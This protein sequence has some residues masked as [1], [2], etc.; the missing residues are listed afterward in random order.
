MKN[1]LEQRVEICKDVLKHLESGKIESVRNSFFDNR[2]DVIYPLIGS[3]DAPR[4]AQTALEKAKVCEVC[5]K[6]AI[7]VS[8][9]LRHNAVTL[10]ELESMREDV[11][12]M[13]PLL[14]E[15]F[16]KPLLDALETAY[17]G[18]KYSTWNDS[19]AIF[20][21]FFEENEEPEERLKILM[22]HV[23]EHN[24]YLEFWE[25]KIG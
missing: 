13:P 24:G 21:S 6:G 11:G 22:E 2:N 15:V 14:V 4:S 20:E 8:W 9:I 23:I 16:G 17:E 10:R 18:H 12:S 19:P 3:V 7:A 25:H 1:I 5:A